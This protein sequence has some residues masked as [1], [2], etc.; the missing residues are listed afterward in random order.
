MINKKLKWY[1]PIE[2]SRERLFE[3]A[4]EQERIQQV[5]AKKMYYYNNE[6]REC[7]LNE[8]WVRESEHQK[9]ASLASPW[10]F[11][12]GM[13]AIRGYYV[14]KHTRDRE[15]RLAAYKA[16]EPDFEGSLGH[17]DCIYRTANTPIIYIAQDGKTAQCMWFIA[18]Q[19]TRG[20]PQG[21]AE[22]NHLYGRA[23]IDL[24][25]EDDEWRIWHW[26][27]VYDLSCRVGERVADLPVFPKLEDEP[28][29]KE[30]VEGNPTISMIT[31][32]YNTH[33]SDGWPAF[34]CAHDT[35]NLDNS[36]A[37]EGHPG[38][39][40]DCMDANWESR[41]ASYEAWGR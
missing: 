41:M 3:R 4:F 8:L 22:A 34:P 26:A 10:G 37:P 9:S 33:S 1:E 21:K 40:T 23:G 38:I 14:D 28:F 24:I 16:S 17:G 39:R 25:L 15:T 32:F 11:Y 36:Y 12:V 30:F 2:Q 13:D 27:E 6:L 5:V 35:Y 29:Y 7:E 20:L 18:G 31:H 19:E